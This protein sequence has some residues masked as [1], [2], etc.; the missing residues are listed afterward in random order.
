MGNRCGPSDGA[1]C[2]ATTHRTHG[3]DDLVLIAKRLVS[4]HWET[5][6]RLLSVLFSGLESLMP[7]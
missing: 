2:L 7:A 1:V 5:G 4:S 6:A 3:D